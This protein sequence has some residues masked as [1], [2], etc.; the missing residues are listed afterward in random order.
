MRERSSM[1]VRK[2]GSDAAKGKNRT[3]RQS[4]NGAE[5]A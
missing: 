4:Q 1:D 5:S 3:W 2:A